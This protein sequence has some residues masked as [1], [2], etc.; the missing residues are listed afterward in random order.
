MSENSKSTRAKP[1]LRQVISSVFA[2]GFG[3]QS[4][5]A[6]HRD[7]AHGSPAVYVVVGV[8]A[9][10]LFVLGVVMLVKLVLS[11]VG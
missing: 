9:T 11:S 6:R 1:S 5:A 7:F 4:S 10:L 2:A 8:V 3:V